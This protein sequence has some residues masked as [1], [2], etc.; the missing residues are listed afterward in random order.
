MPIIEFRGQLAVVVVDVDD[1]TGDEVDRVEH[2][3][4]DRV[5]CPLGDILDDLAD[6]FGGLLDPVTDV[7][8]GLLDPVAHVFGGLPNRSSTTSSAACS[9]QSTASSTAAPMSAKA[10]SNQFISGFPVRWHAAWWSWHPPYGTLGD[11]SPG[12]FPVVTAES[13]AFGRCV[14][15]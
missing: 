9:T 6:V 10:C 13:R 12:A 3:I 1:A 11:T 5:E 7:F 14:Y 15:H 8:G 2:V 4:V